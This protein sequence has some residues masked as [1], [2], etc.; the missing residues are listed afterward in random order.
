M[1]RSQRSPA[2]NSRLRF[3][4][5]IWT[6]ARGQATVVL[7]CGGQGLERS[8]DCK[9]E[10]LVGGGKARLAPGISDRSFVIETDE[11]HAKV[12]WRLFEPEAATTDPDAQPRTVGRLEEP[13]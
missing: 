9:L 5:E 12:A 7:P 2:R 10:I 4:G 13:S 3:S 1:A 6:D 11:P 8:L